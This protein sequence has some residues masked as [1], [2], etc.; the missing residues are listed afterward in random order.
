MAYTSQA[1]KVHG[2]AA[3]NTVGNTVMTFSASLAVGGAVLRAVTIVN[4]NTTLTR[5][6]TI[7]LVPL[8]GGASAANEIAEVSVSPQ[9]TVI[10]R[11]PWYESSQAFIVAKVDAGTDTIIRVTANELT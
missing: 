7:N 10:V 9:D 6:V 4:S 8:G 5:K 3:A 2:G 11:G 1:N